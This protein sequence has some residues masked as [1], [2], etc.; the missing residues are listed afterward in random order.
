MMDDRVK[1]NEAFNCSRN[2]RS[3]HWLPENIHMRLFLTALLPLLIAPAQAL[4]DDDIS[5]LSKAELRK[6]L[7][8]MPAERALTEFLPACP[9]DYFG[10]SATLF[11]ALGDREGTSEEVCAKQPTAC[12]TECILGKNSE[13]CFN[14]ARIIQDSGEPTGPINTERLFAFACASGEPSACT[15]RAAGMRNG[16]YEG[17]P[18]LEWPDEKLNGCLMRTFQLSCD[19]EDSWGCAMLGQAHFYGEGGE[20]NMEKAKAAFERTCDLAPD[21]ASCEFVQSMQG[22]IDNE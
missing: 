22:V 6:V 8:R 7:E 18:A 15:N 13:T 3:L 12:L 17:D 16:R 21:F 2:E 9:A 5:P 20:E 11:D 19:K 4:G 10:K 14:L 1:P